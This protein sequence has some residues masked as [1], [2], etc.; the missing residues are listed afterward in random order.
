MTAHVSTARH[1]LLSHCRGAL[2]A[3]A[4][5]LAAPL[6]HAANPG[7][8]WVYVANDYPDDVKDLLAHG[9]DPNVRYKNGQPALMRAVVDGAWKVFDVIAADKRTDVNAENPAGETPLMYLAIAGQTERAKKL[10]AR[11][12]EVNRLGWTPLHYAASKGQMEMARLLLSKKAM[13]NAPAPGGETPLMM[14]ALGGSKEMVDLLLKAGA[15][16]TTRDLKGQSAADWARN[17]KS[18]SLATELTAMVAKADDAKRARRAANPAP[19]GAETAPAPEQAAAPVATPQAQPAPAAA[20]APA[21]AAP[22][23][24]PNVGGVSGVRLNNYDT[25]ASP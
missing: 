15:D 7:D 9:S 18:A 8:W 23:A 10:I 20:P 19:E 21:T 12:A 14:A 17:G 13:V 6:A 5:G 22:S 11:G 3:L 1:V 24:A 2:L 16:V 25:P 4:V